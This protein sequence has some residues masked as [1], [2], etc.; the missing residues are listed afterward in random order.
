VDRERCLEE[1]FGLLLVLGE[2]CVGVQA[3]RSCP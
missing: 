3:D 2:K 1:A